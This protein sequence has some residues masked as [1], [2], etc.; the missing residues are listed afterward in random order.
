MLQSRASVRGRA[1]TKLAE[2][3]AGKQT[4]V[5]SLLA[6]MNIEANVTKRK[7]KYDKA[8]RNYRSA[9]IDRGTLPRT[10]LDYRI[11]F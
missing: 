7:E 3:Q 4:I 10:V 8:G 11:N 1:G 2:A 6:D 9:F 5:V